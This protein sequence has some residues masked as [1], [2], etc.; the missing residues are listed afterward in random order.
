MAAKGVLKKGPT[1]KFRFSLRAGNGEIHRDERGL[2]HEG[3]AVLCFLGLLSFASRS[4]VP[5]S[6]GSVPS[7]GGLA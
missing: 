4:P 2:Q 5:S 3:R 6:A 1:G 7:E